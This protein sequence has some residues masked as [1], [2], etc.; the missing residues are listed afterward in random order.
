MKTFLGDDA[1]YGDVLRLALIKEF[2]SL[3]LTDLPDTAD[4]QWADYEQLDFQGPLD[5]PSRWI[6][7]YCIRKALIRKHFLVNTV[8]EYLAKNPASILASAVPKSWIIEV[9]YAEFLDDALDDAFELRS[10]LELNESCDE[11]TRKWY[12]LKPGMADRG[13]GLRLFSTI[14][15]LTQIFEEN[16]ASDHDED[17]DETQTN[18]VMTSD[19]RFYVVQEYLMIPL[20]LPVLELRKFH[21]RAYVVAIGA[22][23]VYIHRDSLLVLTSQQPYTPPS[24]GIT[25]LGRH[26]TNTCYQGLSAGN[27]HEYWAL[28]DAALD[29]QSI[30]QDIQ[31]VV[32][33][34]FSAAASQRINFQPLPNAFEIFGLDFMVDEN[35]AVSFLEA[36]AY[37]DFSQTGTDLKHLIDDVI[38]NTV[39]AVAAEMKKTSTTSTKYGAL[40]LCLE[41]NLMG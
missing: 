22:L 12:I 10:V 9:D 36:N 21:I 14:A 15:E 41:Q 33:D 25:E 6:C 2:G 7:A 28:E 8:Q 39:A 29:K 4:L 13:A 5:D 1:Y 26:L 38:T 20:L 30:W 18:G 19:M 34:I 32:H 40:K 37:P 11:S 17:D 3:E 35:Q 16:E 23:K 31:T 24:L 27:V